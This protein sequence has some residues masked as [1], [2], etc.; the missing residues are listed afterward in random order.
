MSV[1]ILLSEAGVR[2]RDAGNGAPKR[3]SNGGGPFVEVL[4]APGRQRPG[5]D[6]RKWN[7]TGNFQ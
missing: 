5:T 2:E 1:G 6:L 7:P 3:S 4:G